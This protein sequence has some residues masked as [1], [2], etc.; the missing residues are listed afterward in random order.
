MQDRTGQGRARAE[1][2]HF[3]TTGR[4]DSRAEGGRQEGWKEGDG[5]GGKQSRPPVDEMQGSRARREVLGKAKGYK[6]R[7]V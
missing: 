7:C 5:L 4:R 2:M 6:R 3:P 1:Y